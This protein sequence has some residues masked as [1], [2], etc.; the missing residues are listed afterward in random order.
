MTW[1]R[2][3]AGILQGYEQRF[4]EENLGPHGKLHT[5]QHLPGEA[6]FYLNW[7]LTA[8]QGCFK[9]WLLKRSGCKPL[10]A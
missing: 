10:F 6:Y 8:C 7:Y 9:Y 1:C 5:L 2:R 3:G 4:P